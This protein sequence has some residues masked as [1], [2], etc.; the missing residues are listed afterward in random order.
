[1]RYYAGAFLANATCLMLI[2]AAILVSRNLSN[3]P[4]LA[5]RLSLQAVCF[6]ARVAFDNLVEVIFRMTMLFVMDQTIGHDG[7]VQ[8]AG[9]AWL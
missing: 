3:D 8:M 9:N 2:L 7:Y 6:S 1:M 4:S 5:D